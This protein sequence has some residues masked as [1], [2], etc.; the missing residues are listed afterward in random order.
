A[1]TIERVH[2]WLR[3]AGRDPAS[4]GIEPRLN[5][6]TGTPDDWRKVVEEWRGLGATHIHVST[7]GGGLSGVDAHIQRLKE[8]RAVLDA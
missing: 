7:S 5:A 2:G 6:N 8:A 3:E 1:E 4:F